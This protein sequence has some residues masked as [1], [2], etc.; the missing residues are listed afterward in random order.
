ELVNLA[1]LKKQYLYVKSPTNPESIKD[2]KFDENY[3]TQE[4]IG[5][6]AYLQ[7]EFRNV[8]TIEEI[9][10]QLDHGE[11]RNFRIDLDDD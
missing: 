9:K 7:Y 11:Y 5:D 1:I 2:G 8:Y 6:K 3:T 4:S 10:V